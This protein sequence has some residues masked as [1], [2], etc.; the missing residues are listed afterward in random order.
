MAETSSSPFSS[1]LVPPAR[2]RE[3]PT[4]ADPAQALPLP[5]PS[6]HTMGPE[7]GLLHSSDDAG[8]GPGD[9]QLPP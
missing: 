6:R 9:T 7:A 2:R 5:Q 4:A 8:G 3:R 1:S